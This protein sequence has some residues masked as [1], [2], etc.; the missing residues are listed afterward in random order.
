MIIKLYEVERY[1]T[2]TMQR[3]YELLLLLLWIAREIKIQSVIDPG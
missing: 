2:E 1:S 3:P